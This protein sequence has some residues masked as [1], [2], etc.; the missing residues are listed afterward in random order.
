L[1]SSSRSSSSWNPAGGPQPAGVR[2][3]GDPDGL[4]DLLLAAGGLILLLRRRWPVAVFLTTTAIGL[5]Y[6]AAGYPD[7]PATIGLFVATHTLAAEDDGYRSLRLATAGIAVLAVGWLLA[8]DPPNSSQ[9]WMPRCSRSRSM[10][11]SRCSVVLWRMSVA[12]SLA[13]GVL[14]PHP[15][16]SN[17]TNR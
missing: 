5:V 11:A 16:W 17:R 3:L 6:D 13:C 7:G 2:P 1:R 8:A 15:R 4:G 14:R 9:R 10:S 12:G